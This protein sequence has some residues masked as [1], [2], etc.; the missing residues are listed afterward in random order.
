M[1]SKLGMLGTARKLLMSSNKLEIKN[2]YKNKLLY[3]Q[4]CT[5]PKQPY[6]GCKE[7]YG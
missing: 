5:I 6:F 3:F 2:K 1:V 7:F 4:G